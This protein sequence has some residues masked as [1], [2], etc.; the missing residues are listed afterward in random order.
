MPARRETGKR[1]VETSAVRSTRHSAAFYFAA[2]YFAA[3]RSIAYRVSPRLSF[4][5][6]SGPRRTSICRL[7]QRT[8]YRCACSSF[9]MGETHTMAVVP[10]STPLTERPVIMLRYFARYRTGASRIGGSHEDP[11]SPVTGELTGTMVKMGLKEHRAGVARC[12]T[13]A[14]DCFCKLP[15][16]RCR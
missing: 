4:L 5:G 3:S 7:L 1:E 16:R 11:R 8:R 14:V 12:H 9:K 6:V 15:A 10:T 13:Y 2:F